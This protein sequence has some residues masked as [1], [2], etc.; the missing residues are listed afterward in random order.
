MIRYALNCTAGHGFDAWFASSDAC[1]E[2]VAS[3]HI[4]CPVCGRTEVSKAIMAPQVSRQGR[5]DAETGPD[6]GAE[7]GAEQAR[8]LAAALQAVREEVLGSADYVGGAF[9]EEARRIHYGEVEERGIYGE[10]TSAD[11]HDLREEGITCWPLPP[12]P[13]DHN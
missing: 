11:V 5:G 1:D 9:A 6:S 8:R 10:A 7:D 2:Q 3:G 4:G 13:E 12:A